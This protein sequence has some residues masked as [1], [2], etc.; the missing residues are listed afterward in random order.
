MSRQVPEAFSSLFLCML[1]R[2]NE[3]TY[4]AELNKKLH[5]NTPHR[6]CK[7]LMNAASYRPYPP[8]LIPS[9]L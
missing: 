1:N 8:I 4:P 5:E 3:C 2:D 7:P 9:Y 6:G